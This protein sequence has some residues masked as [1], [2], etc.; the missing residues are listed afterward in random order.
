M[1]KQIVS[2][3]PVVAV[4][5]VVSSRPARGR[6]TRMRV[7][8]PELRHIEAHLWRIEDRQ[9]TILAKL[10]RIWN[11][12]KDSGVPV[13]LEKDVKGLADTLGESTERLSDAVERNTPL[14]V[15]EYAPPMSAEAG[16]KY[17][18]ATKSK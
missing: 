5:Q 18:K 1:G 17:K 4:A 2:D 12:L 6:P 14:A 13:D 3:K 11:K 15:R 16:K 7:L 8:D 9:H 10:H